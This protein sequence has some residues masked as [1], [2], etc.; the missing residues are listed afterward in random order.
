M[1]TALTFFLLVGHANSVVIKTAPVTLPIARLFNAT[2]GGPAILAR[3]QARAAAFKSHARLLSGANPRA[4]VNEPVDNVAVT[5][6]ASIGV[7]T[8]PTL[9]EHNSVLSQTAPHLEKTI[10]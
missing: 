6:I 3:D 2:G 8:P 10:S 9:C 1:W 5:Y 4:I 7:G